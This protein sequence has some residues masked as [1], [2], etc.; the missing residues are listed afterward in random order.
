M[1]LDRTP[2]RLQ[3]TQEVAEGTLNRSAEVLQKVSPILKRVEE[4]DGNMKKE[5]YSA[6]AF[7]RTVLS[8]GE[9]GMVDFHQHRKVLYIETIHPFTMSGLGQE[10]L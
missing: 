4:W 2:R 10:K 9:A 5:A 7:D 3:F 8:A 6:A 1:F